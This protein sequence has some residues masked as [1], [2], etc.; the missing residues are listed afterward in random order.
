MICCVALGFRVWEMGQ[1]QLQKDA[2]QTVSGCQ[3]GPTGAQLRISASIGSI[4]V[5]N[6]ARETQLPARCYQVDC[7]IRAGD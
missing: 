3:S 1:V 4:G 2:V 5:A 7:L 6:L